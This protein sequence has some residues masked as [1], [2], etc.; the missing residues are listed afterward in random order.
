MKQ[1]IPFAD[2]LINQVHGGLCAAE[3]AI[4]RS[5]ELMGHLC[6][7]FAFV[8]IE[9]LQGWNLI[10]MGYILHNDHHYS[11][12]VYYVRPQ[13][14]LI[15]FVNHRCL[16]VHHSQI[17]FAFHCVKTIVGELWFWIDYFLA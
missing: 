16:R 10:E 12:V 14:Y 4:Q 1:E 7:H 2:F 15:E 13:G 6:Q 5:P 9:I 17:P 11:F 8:L 3:H